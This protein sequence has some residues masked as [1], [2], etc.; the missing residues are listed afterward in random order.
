MGP[1][2]CSIQ[3]GSIA[4]KDRAHLFGSRREKAFDGICSTAPCR[5]RGLLPSGGDLCMSLTR[6]FSSA[7]SVL[8]VYLKRAFPAEDGDIWAPPSPT[9]SRHS[10]S[11]CVVISTL[12]SLSR[13]IDRCSVFEKIAIPHFTSGLHDLGEPSSSF[14]VLSTFHIPLILP[15][16]CL[17]LAAVRM[18]V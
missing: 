10:P 16:L 3:D 17:R 18:F 12:S 2:L 11:A 13:R 1:Y 4:D 6:S 8:L 9:T 15:W 7:L 5:V 14:L